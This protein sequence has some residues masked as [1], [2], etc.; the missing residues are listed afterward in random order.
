[1]KKKKC[2]VASVETAIAGDN[3]MQGHDKAVCSAPVLR[4]LGPFPTARWVYPLDS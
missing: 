2:A 3:E 4:V 1:M